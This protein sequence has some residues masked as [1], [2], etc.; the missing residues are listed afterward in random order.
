MVLFSSRFIIIEGKYI[1]IHIVTILSSTCSTSSLVC[2]NKFYINIVLIEISPFVPLELV[3]FIP[4]EILYCF[5]KWYVGW[6]LPFANVTEANL[7]QFYRVILFMIFP[8]WLVLLNSIS[9]V[10]IFNFCTKVFFLYFLSIVQKI[11]F[12]KY[13]LLACD[14]MTIYY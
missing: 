4:L 2:T 14:F 6:N 7:L 5:T 10:W 9:Q 11:I 3:W 12:K 13:L 8:P 1:C